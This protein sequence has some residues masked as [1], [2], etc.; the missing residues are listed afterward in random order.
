MWNSLPNDVAEAYTINIVKNCLVTY[1][2][3]QYVLYNFN[4]DLIGTGSSA[5]LYVK[6]MLICGQR[7]LPVPVR[8]Y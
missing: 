2:S 7:G 4:A 5:S 1:R 6:V 3:K 8:T